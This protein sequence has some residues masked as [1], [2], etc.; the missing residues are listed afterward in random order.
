VASRTHVWVVANHT[1]LTAHT[2]AKINQV[3]NL[4]LILLNNVYVFSLSRLHLLSKIITGYQ[5]APKFFSV[6]AVD[7]IGVT[8]LLLTSSLGCYKQR[9]FNKNELSLDS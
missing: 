4:A 9:I 2:T 5:F 3:K 8:A 7:P 1:L 6:T